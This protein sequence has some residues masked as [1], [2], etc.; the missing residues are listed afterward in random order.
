MFLGHFSKKDLGKKSVK[1]Y[2][3]ILGV[4][5]ISFAIYRLIKLA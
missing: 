2:L 1:I 5:A 4:A 3:A